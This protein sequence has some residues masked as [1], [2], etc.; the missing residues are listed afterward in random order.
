MDL[1]INLSGLHTQQGGG[2]PSDLQASLHHNCDAAQG[3]LQAVQQAHQALQ[4][5]LA[6]RCN[7][8]AKV[9][10][11]LQ[12]SQAEVQAFQHKGATQ[13]EKLLQQLQSAETLKADALAQVKQLAAALASAGEEHQVNCM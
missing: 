6:D 4:H 9:Q 3:M 11:A 2:I 13:A 1:P 7:E 12:H 8:L 10:A 5:A